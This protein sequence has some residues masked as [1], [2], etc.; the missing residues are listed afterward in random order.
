MR[1]PAFS[2]LL[3][4]LIAACTDPRGAPVRTG[5]LTFADS[6]DQVFYGVQAPF[7]TNGV[8][9]GTLYADTLY[10]LNDQTRFD[11]KVGHVDFN[12]ETGT[13]NGSMKADRGRYDQRAQILEGWGNVVVKTVDGRS[14]K[15]PHI[16]YNQTRNEISSDTTFEAVLPGGRVNTGVGFTS[17]PNFAHYHCI[18]DCNV[19]GAV[20]IPK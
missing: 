17:D 19:T 8:K 10:V 5:A 4:I 14:L 3:L 1:L 20:K 13:P 7:E 16:V 6:A 11:F 9:R 12:T 18:R 2:V 15:S